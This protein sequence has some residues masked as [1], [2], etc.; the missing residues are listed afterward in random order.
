MPSWRAHGQ[1]HLYTWSSVSFKRAINIRLK[2][3]LI[4]QTPRFS[5]RLQY[6]KILLVGKFDA[7]GIY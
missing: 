4:F 3:Y 2:M 5:V 7:M 1:F 6:R